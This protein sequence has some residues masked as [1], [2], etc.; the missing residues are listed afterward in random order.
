MSKSWRDVW[1]VHPAADAFPLLSQDELRKLADNIKA[2]GLQQRIVFWAEKP[3]AEK[4]LLD[5]RNRCDALELVGLDP[6]SCSQT[7]VYGSD[8]V[9]PRQ[10][11]I[12]ANI[13]RRHLNIEQRQ[14]LLIQ[15]IA[16]DPKKSDRQ[17]GKDTGVD[18][19]TIARARAKGEDVGRIPHVAKRTDTKGR[20]QPAR[21]QPKKKRR[22]IEDFQADIRAKQQSA[23]NAEAAEAERQWLNSV[24]VLAGDCIAMRAS[25]SKHFPGWEK[26]EVPSDIATLIRQ[27][28]DAWNEL[29]NTLAARVG[30]N[31]PDTVPVRKKQIEQ[32]IKDV[33]QGGN[34]T[35][36]GFI[37][38][39]S[40]ASTNTDG[41]DIP[42]FLR[43]TA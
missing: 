18:H 15:L 30:K 43:R 31:E 42:G 32:A 5:G 10:Y 14:D 37:N 40:G 26:F 38:R 34:Q 33:D 23:P 8:G 16:R 25:W 3:G 12:S 1:P 22:T 21:K 13:H 29:A 27:A 28:A 2:R 6:L 39:A 9:D 24:G 7:T 35:H 19:K 4:F 20:K 36:F 17:I 41:L 11:V